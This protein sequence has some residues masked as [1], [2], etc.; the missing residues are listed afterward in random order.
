MKSPPK[1]LHWRGSIDIAKKTAFLD[2]VV[3][4]NLKY[5]FYYSAMENFTF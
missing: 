4:D 2:E 3:Y 1:P 5:R